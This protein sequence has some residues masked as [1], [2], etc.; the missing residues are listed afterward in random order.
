MNSDPYLRPGHDAIGSRIFSAR[1]EPLGATTD[2]ES[3]GRQSAV[4]RSYLLK[5]E[6]C[7]DDFAAALARRRRCC[8]ATE[9]SPFERD[10]S[11]TIVFERPR[12][13]PDATSSR[14]VEG[15]RDRFVKVMMPLEISGRGSNI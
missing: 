13:D 11:Q 15:V 10:E 1:P 2:S 6:I 8:P 9:R 7:S 5:S 3:A 14:A 4:Q 12:V